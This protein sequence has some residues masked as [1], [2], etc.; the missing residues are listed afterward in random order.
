MP[1]IVDSV[2]RS[3]MMSGIRGK[4]TKPEVLVRRALHARGFRFSTSNMRLPGRPDVVLPRWRVAVFVNGCFWHSHGCRLSKLPASNRLFW[5][6]KLGHNEDRDARAQIS[7]ISMGWR[8]AMVWECSLRG[9]AALATFDAAM[10]E[11]AH[12]IRHQPAVA[13]FETGAAL[14]NAEVR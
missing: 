6:A 1:D 2:T 13:V 11:L 10:N 8:V 14:G 3:R 12:W 5:K 4:N 7:L 9:Q